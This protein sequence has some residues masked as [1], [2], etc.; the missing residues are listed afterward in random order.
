[1][2]SVIIVVHLIIVVSLVGVVLLQRSEGGGLGMGSGGGGGVSGFMTGRGQANALTRA[3]AILAAAFFVTSI[4][5]AV[6]S[7]Q[8]RT[9]RSIIDGAPGTPAATT[10]PAA[11]S[12][13]SAPSAGGQG[14]ILDQLQRMQDQGGAQPPRPANPQ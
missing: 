14:G 3:T 12:A 10:A 2:Q 7:S 1:M 11:P 13:P 5:L 8:S 6:I 9:Q 4:T